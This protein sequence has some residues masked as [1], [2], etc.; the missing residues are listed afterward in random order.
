V[1][2]NVNVND[3]VNVNVN[4]NNNVIKENIKRKKYYEDEKLNDIFLEFLTIRKKLKAVNSDR[5]I[6]MLLKT[7]SNY[8]D[9][10]KYKMIEQSVV[11]SWKSVYELKLTKEEIKRQKELEIEKWLKEQ[12]DE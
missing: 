3:N 6:D 9:E 5:A 2:P 12:E 1:K 10:T 11:N 7:L 8:D 4:D